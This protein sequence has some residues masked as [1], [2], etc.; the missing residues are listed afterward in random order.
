MKRAVTLILAFLLSLTLGFGFAACGKSTAV[1]TTS[2]PETLP[3]TT[4]ATTAASF[5]PPV[6]YRDHEII[7]GIYTLG[8]TTY[9]FRYSDGLF[10]DDP[11][12]YGTH[13]ATMS[14][15]ISHAATKGSDRNNDFSHAADQV[16][17]VL[18]QIG[19]TSVYVSPSYVVVPTENSVG[20]VIA[21]KTLVDNRRGIKRVISV[22]FRSGG[23]EAEWTSNFHLGLSGEAQGVAECADRVLDEYLSEFLSH[24]DAITGEIERGEVAFWVAGYSRGGALANLFAKRLIDYFGAAGNDVYAYCIEPQRAG[25]PEAEKPGCDYS[26]IH[27]VVN[28]NDPIVYLSPASMGFIRY[29]VDHY[30]FSDPADSDNPIRDEEG[31]PVSD[32][33]RYETISEKRLVLTKNHLLALLGDEDRAEKYMPRSVEY[34]GLNIFTEEIVDLVRKTKTASYVEGILNGLSETKDGE[35]VTDRTTYVECGMEAAFGRMMSYLN[36]DFDM[37]DVSFDFDSLSRSISDAMRECRDV[38]SANVVWVRGKATFN[39]HGPA[40]ASLCDALMTR[41]REE[42]S[43]RTL[44][45]DYPDGGAERAFE[46]LSI[47]LYRFLYSTTDFDDLVTFAYNFVSITMNHEYLQVLA[48]LRTYDSWFDASGSD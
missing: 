44:F 37:R 27:N 48:V 41:L 9:P 26:S 42:N 16:S 15:S 21:E 47:L 33:F 11:R 32:N 10:E 6:S 24:N 43:I 25:V 1:E 2:A 28:P 30:L 8:N 7:D 40:A 36:T 29:G 18:T 22:T 12:V 46:D 5:D 23:Y 3:Q 31:R 34:K 35:T 39:I 38:L 4:A 14:A 19:F 45:A 17:S 13:L 20:C